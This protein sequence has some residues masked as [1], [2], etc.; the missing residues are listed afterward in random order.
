MKKTLLLILFFFSLNSF[1]QNEKL[2]RLLHNLN[3][4]KSIA[5]KV[6]TLLEI[7][8]VYNAYNKYDEALRYLK[9]S[10][11]ISLTKNYLLGKAKTAY[12]RGLVYKTKRLYPKAKRQ[13]E[14]A[15]DY[16]QEE[17]NENLQSNILTELG[18]VYIKMKDYDTAAD[19]LVD[20][21]QL[22]REIKNPST[23]VSAL[24][25][26][27]DLNLKYDRI[28]TVEAQLEEARR[29][30][31]SAKSEK[32]LL[33]NYLLMRK[34]QDKLG[35]EEKAREWMINYREL[36]NKIKDPVFTTD[37][38]NLSDVN[39]YYLEN[40]SI[41]NDTADNNAGNIN[42]KEDS[43]VN[44]YKDEPKKNPNNLP[45]FETDSEKLKKLQLF[46]YTLFGL[47]VALIVAIFFLLRRINNPKLK[48]EKLTKDDK[49]QI[50]KLEEQNTYLEKEIDVKNRLFSIISHD[51]KDALTST[52]GF[53][54]L[55]K[56]GNITDD[57]FKTLIPVVSNNADNASL[58][59]LN[60]LNWSKSQMESLDAKGSIFDIKEV[61]EDK[62]KLL[63][64]RIKYK[65][66]VI[67][68][69]TVQ[70]FAY[71]DKNMVEIVVQNLLANAVKFSKPGDKIILK[72]SIEDGKCQFSVS[73]TGVGISK[74]DQ[75]KLFSDVNFTTIGT[76]NEK[77]N[78]L[79]L[80][81]CKEMV[82]LNEG[83]IW[84]ESELGKGT[85]F[86]VE[87]PKSK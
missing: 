22:L 50:K 73:D 85:S 37:N 77:G 84:V 49:I 82:E 10:D 39:P 5:Q 19:Y 20:A 41:S 46:T 66:I 29:I 17:G 1:S 11:S 40:F 27:G 75:D 7:S 83:K 25:Y 6:D 57:E 47:I 16:A 18:G 58:L 61:I 31:L 81:I 8:K 13:L 26:F 15:L 64:S 60:L 33:Q 62:V 87:L 21:I 52:K 69:N 14:K 30:G 71:A 28:K 36:K 70:D 65:N 53:I 74:E 23:L 51:L 79:G 34:L 86:F 35:N 42:L 55:I 76:S 24:N 63:N 38:N 67:E 12:T 2:D 45:V 54:D 56:D 72:N 43:I 68:N 78:G 44:S 80:S 4:T 59:I 9:Y 32:E 3:L 48:P